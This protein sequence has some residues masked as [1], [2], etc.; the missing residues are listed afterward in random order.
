MSGDSQWG[1][2]MSHSGKSFVWGRSSDI[3]AGRCTLVIWIVFSVLYRWRRKEILWI[4]EAL[5]PTTVVIPWNF[6]KLSWSKK[7]FS[8][9]FRWQYAW[10]TFEWCR[11]S[12]M[13]RLQADHLSL[14]KSPFTPQSVKD[15]P[16]CHTPESHPQT[17]LPLCWV[18][19][20]EIIWSCQRGIHLT[21]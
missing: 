16:S 5:G 21:L 17:E 6:T 2:S 7:M 15:M 13:Q 10:A 3:P 11:L 19:E 9:Y 18:Q 8:K 20:D 14:Y 1:L 12:T 4:R